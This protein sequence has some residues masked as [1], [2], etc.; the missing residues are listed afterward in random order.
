MY[1]NTKLKVLI[2]LVALAQQLK[3]YVIRINKK[4][5]KICGVQSVQTG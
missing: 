2:I 1:R 3:M 5:L 4:K